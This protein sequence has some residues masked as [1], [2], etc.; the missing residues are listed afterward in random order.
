MA[1]TPIHSLALTQSLVQLL[2]SSPIPVTTLAELASWDLNLCGR[3]WCWEARAHTTYACSPDVHGTL[4]DNV[5]FTSRQ[6]TETGS[7]CPV[8][9]RGRGSVL[10]SATTSGTNHQNCSPAWP[11]KGNENAKDNDNLLSFK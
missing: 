5:P 1:W 8:L 9:K 3:R 10:L 7:S 2:A 11:Y 6:L 4:Q